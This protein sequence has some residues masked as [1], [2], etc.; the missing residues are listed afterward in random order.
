MESS[1]INGSDAFA[2][3][4]ADVDFLAT[5]LGDTMRE[6][7]GPELFELVEHVRNL[8]KQLRASPAGDP[9]SRQL[10]AE[11]TELISSLPAVQCDLLVRAFG[12]YF[13][14]VNLAEEIHR[15][16]VNRQREAV[17]TSEAP[18]SESV[19]A[20]VKVLRDEGWSATE[21][22]NFLDRLDV[23]LTITAHP[24]EVRRY[25]VRLKLERIGEALR[26]LAETELSPVRRNLLRDEIRA[27][28]SALWQTR[29]LP[30][31]KPRVEDEAKSAL[32]YF[33]RSIL[34]VLP[35]I[36]QDLESAFDTYFDADSP[37]PL[38]PV[39]RFRSWIGGDRDGNPNVTPEVLRSVT[40]LQAELAR[41]SAQS[42]LDLMVQRLSL[43]DRRSE[44]G[45]ALKAVVSGRR[46]ESGVAAER[47]PDEPY[48]Q[49]VWL[50]H[51]GLLAEKGPDGGY[52]AGSKGYTAD[53][54]LLEE[55][56]EESGNSRIA[57]SFVRPALYRAS[58]FGLHLAALDTRENS[59]VHER[60]I[61]DLFA[62]ARVTYEYQELAEEER[63]ELL[64]RELHSGRPLAGLNSQLREDTRQALEF[65]SVLRQ[66][67]ERYGREAVGSY[68]VSMTEGV[69]DVL[70][71]L[72]LA[73]EAG[74]ADLDVTPLFE[75]R[76]DLANAPGIIRE[77]L[78]I[79]A[80]LQHV[81]RRGVQEIMIG[82]SDS[83]KDAGFLTANWALY[84]AQEGVA[85]ACRDAGVNWRIFH[86]RGTS[87]GRGGGP[88]GLAI[89]AQPPGSLAG[90]M[91][92]TEQGEALSARYS[93]RDLAHRHLE[94]LVHAFLLSSARESTGPAEA[95]PEH[96]R[97][98][99]KAS[100]A[101]FARYR[102]L[103]EAD[104]FLDFYHSVTPI[105]EL[106]RLQIGSRPARRKGERSLRN[107]RAIPWVFSWTQCRAILPGWFGLGSGLA[108]VELSDL[109]AM[110]RDW[111]FVSTVLDFAQMSLK[112]SDMTVFRAWLQL[113]P[114][115]LRER[116][117][118]MV[119]AEY[120]LSVR[121]VEEVTGESFLE[122]DTTLVR[123]VDLRNPYVDPLSYLQVELLE[124]LRSGQLDDAE[125]DQLEYSM[126][127]SLQGVS[128][129][130][131]NTG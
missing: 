45:E 28:I 99:K 61:A 35:Q 62:Q 44:A 59:S 124:R 77:L 109:Q 108:A 9:Q 111:P 66:T 130:L 114:D 131:R 21:I 120:D 46:A 113:V 50:M 129:A 110:Y 84:E 127:V 106:S 36:L 18:R 98:M 93:D 72:V 30:L 25:T 65:I 88:T 1:L 58:A 6:L 19:L 37:T 86:G 85:A 126:M 83:N 53:L 32:Y 22:R 51:E 90:R 10:Q 125:R 101:A 4:R 118:D 67:R 87:I 38:P 27:E 103:L 7:E 128:A 13:Q 117:G 123:S 24:T 75:T 81:Q 104:G 54:E 76:E 89:L 17:A 49:L 29:E 57:R 107:L 39:I 16:R 122:S 112:K 78:A 26:E 70:E 20:A 40:E 116:F 92:I 97:T 48:R 91:R 12:T 100:D 119:F 80:Y 34:E 47:F 55:S 69:S 82:Y 63:C 2:P 105:E 33:R 8:T 71:V 60:V 115:G 64:I 68:V 11:L 74:L 3:L 5:A 79:P 14:L 31:D 15:V 96:R 102:E 121:L 94:Q 56:L 23:Q 41:E 73:R 42:D 52:P 95:L 43:W